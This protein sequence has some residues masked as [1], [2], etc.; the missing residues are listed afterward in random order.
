MGEVDRLLRLGANVNSVDE[1]G[2]S[3]LHGACAGGHGDIV[4]RLLWAGADI[5]LKDKNGAKAKIKNYLP[6]LAVAEVGPLSVMEALLAANVDVNEVHA[7][8]GHTA[9]H[10]AAKSGR[11]DLLEC[12]LAHKPIVDVRDKR[13]RTALHFAA[14]QGHIKCTSLLLDNG[15]DP[16]S[17]T[18]AGT[19]ALHWA[20]VMCS[21]ETIKELLARGADVNSR[22]NE[23]FTAMDRAPAGAPDSKEEQ[24]RQLLRGNGAIE[25]LGWWSLRF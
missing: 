1:L 3:A 22:N 8:T 18:E 24:V 4:A 20:V 21:L 12:I 6:L 9:L 2:Q 17:K 19:T 11:D 10:L 7:T 23:G 25:S 13:G 15:A 5:N 14:S 16:N